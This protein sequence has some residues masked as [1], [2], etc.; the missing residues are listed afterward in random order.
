M[1]DYG[2]VSIILPVYNGA[3]HLHKSINSIM[4]QTYTNW[5]LIAVNDC[6]TDDTLSIL[7][8]YALKDS[9]I[10]I[11]SNPSNLKLPR[12]LNAGFSISNGQYLTWTSDDNMYKPEAINTLVNTLHNNPDVDM[13]YSDYTNIDSHDEEIDIVKLGD[14]KLLIS[15]NVIGAC[16]LYTRKIAKIVGTYDSNLFLAEDYD[17]WIRIYA[18]GKILHIKDNL[19]LYRRHAGSLTETKKEM[20]QLQTYKMLEKNFMSLY[21]LAL[22]NKQSNLLFDQILKRAGAE[23]YSSVKDQLITINHKYKYYLLINKFKTKMKEFLYKY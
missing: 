2:L 18:N 10:K 19:Y 11:I 20:I 15:G 14:P 17:Y 13:V 8:K 16:F 12:T 5:E 1:N 23:L 22:K 4:A 3:S 6:S 21:A 7:E 9:R